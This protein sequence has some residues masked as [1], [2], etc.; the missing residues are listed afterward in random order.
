MQSCIPILKSLAF[1]DV[2]SLLGISRVCSNES[3]ST[4]ARAISIP[5]GQHLGGGLAMP[6]VATI[7]DIVFFLSRI[8]KNLFCES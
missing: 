3:K 4:L 8:K 6:L 7:N 5:V 2:S 1:L